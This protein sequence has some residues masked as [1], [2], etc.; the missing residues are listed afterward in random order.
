MSR[1]LTTL[2]LMLIGSSLLNAAEFLGKSR[3]QWEADLDSPDATVRRSAAF[4]LGKM[5]SSARLA[6]DVL[7]RRLNDPSPVVREMVAHA[8]GE[9]AQAS[10]FDAKSVWATAGEA[11]KT[12]I[13]PSSKADPALRREATYALGACANF[14]DAGTQLLRIE[15]TK[16]DAS[17]AERQNAAWALGPI[18]LRGSRESV[19]A[20]M[21]V[22][23]KPGEDPMVH[24]SAAIAV[25]NIG[26]P[27]ARVAV[28]SLVALVRRK[29]DT[30]VLK[31]ALDALSKLVEPGD[32]IKASDFEDFLKHRDAET[33]LAAAFVIANSGN[34]A[35]RLVPVLAEELRRG[36]PLTLEPVTAALA[37]AGPDAVQALDE[38]IKLLN[39]SKKPTFARRNAALALGRLGPR[40]SKA[41]DAL[42]LALNQSSNSPREVKV[43]AA[44]ALLAIGHPLNLPAKDQML[45]TLKDVNEDDRVR[46]SIIIAMNRVPDWKSYGVYDP[47]VSILSETGL[48]SANARYNT[49]IMMGRRLKADVPLKAIDILEGL[50]RSENFRIVDPSRARSSGGT[51][52]KGGGSDVKARYGRDARHIVAS[53]LAG[54][55]KKAARADVIKSLERLVTSAT[56]K[57]VS[58]AASSALMVL[59]PLLP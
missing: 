36:D 38:L 5:G 22:L 18:T 58:E 16:T 49:A 20:L 43:Y 23:E 8:L 40:A 24:R 10:L 48:A 44:R 47:L 55:G 29:P 57:R 2:L 11:L 35:L 37:N 6:I 54:I 19:K 46:S 12:V 30:P 50:L 41:V 33:R 31:P 28:G 1:W 53:T 21:T 7:V 42:A 39:D 14:N 25:K 51:E 27:D 13:S 34:Q 9:I 17:A 56:D 15:S 4:A 52:G 3:D 26:R 45:T 59:R 32:G